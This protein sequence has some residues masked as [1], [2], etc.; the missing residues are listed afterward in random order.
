MIS[1]LPLHQ[2]TDRI[3]GQILSPS[4]SS[5]LVRL[6][7]NQLGLI[8]PRSL[9]NRHIWP[10][11]SPVTHLP[12]HG[13]GNVIHR[14]QLLDPGEQSQCTPSLH[15]FRNISFRCGLLTRRRTGAS[16][17]HSRSVPSIRTV[18]RNGARHGN[19]VVL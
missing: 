8:N 2:N 12:T 17:I 13:H 9:Y 3:L 15:C 6:G 11:Q 16:H 19:D 18:I 10:T 4:C 1:I 7:P 5:R 14:L